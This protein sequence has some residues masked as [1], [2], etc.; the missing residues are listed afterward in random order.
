M[1]ARQFYLGAVCYFTI[2]L[3]LSR[4][5]NAQPLD[6]YGGIISVRCAGGQKPHFYTEKR[7]HRWWLCT[8]DGNGFFM[9]G[10]YN[11]TYTDSSPDYQGVSLANTIAV[12][13]G[14]GITS[15]STLNW[16]LAQVRRLK[17]WGFNTLSEYSS[18][19]TWA[20]NT[21]ARW[22]TPDSAIPDKLPFVVQIRPSYYAYTNL[23]NWGG[24]PVKDLVNGITTKAYSGWR[25][26]IPDIFDPHYS[27]FVLNEFSDTVVVQAYTS[28][29]RKYLVGFDID[30]TDDLQGFG[31][32][33]DFPTVDTSYSGGISTG[34]ANPN[35]AWMI[36]ATAST[37]ANNT[38]FRQKYAD[39]TTYSKLATIR[40]LSAR[41]RNNISALNV[42][43]G[44]RYTS[45]GSAG[46]FGLG[47]GLLDEDGTCPSRGNSVCW[48]GNAVSLA[49]ETRAM[50]AD[51]SALLSFYANRY[52]SIIRKAFNVKAPGYLLLGSSPLGSWGAPPR[53]EILEV[54]SR[55]LDV[56]T[57]GNIP[58]FI[59]SNCIDVQQRIAF[60]ARY[61]GDK[62]WL[63]W[64]GFPA[65]AD[66]YWAPA[67]S[68]KPSYATTQIQRGDLYKK[69]MEGL[70]NT[71]DSN[72]TYHI[73][74]FE[75]W[76][77]Y[78]MR[79]E[80][81]NWGLLTPRD[82]AYDGVQA[83][84]EEGTDAWGYS[85]GGEHTSYGDFLSA[86]MAANKWIDVALVAES[87][88][89]KPAPLAG[90]SS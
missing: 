56:L 58:P 5:A 35:I 21:D 39:S 16:A 9:K 11:V 15:N 65:Q 29:N 67:V 18:S 85:T 46:G 6:A 26:E 81:T 4:L 76:D 25:S 66:S 75:W 40:W 80:Q 27:R 55:Y 1:M 23:N 24:Q 3:I 48:I 57:L 60:V 14:N 64:E 89:L 62:P 47:T 36:L 51:M 31:A 77:L 61:G 37:Q 83:V 84:E 74:G 73:V 63:N 20:T 8:P 87:K 50:Q 19:Y 33:P 86:V 72:G 45:F 10:V 54:A 49:G 88:G 34:Y 53:K 68:V 79:R 42:A 71:M 38:H 43:W 44:S 22:N 2:L 7:H 12:K 70:L 59:C 17:S 78:D 82:N 52:Y 32:G 90:A 41:Y 30:E 28:P 13:Y 69:M